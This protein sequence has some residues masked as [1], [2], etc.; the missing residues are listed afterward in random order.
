MPQRLAAAAALLVLLLPGCHGPRRECVPA[1][2]VRHG[3]LTD[4]SP[5][6]EA[7]QQSDP[8][9]FRAFAERLRNQ[10]SP[11]STPSRRINVLAL[12]GGG[13]YGAF[14]AGT[15][16]GWSETGRR[17]CFDIVT[18][19]STGALIA[20][21]AFLGPAYDDPLGRF[22]LS[23]R[24]QDVYH[25]RPYSVALF[26]DAAASSAPLE[27]LIERS[28]TEPMVQEIA[29]AHRQGRRLFVATTN[30]DTHRSVVWDLGAIAASGRPDALCLFR[31][32][33]LASASVPGFLPPV[34][35]DVEVNGRR[36]TEAH[37][38]GG[39]TNQVFL[40]GNA[41]G[42]DPDALRRGESPLK[43]S[44][45]YVIIAGKLYADP[46]CIRERALDIGRDAVSTL[47][48][49]QT[50]NDLLRVAFLCYLT[51][52]RFQLTSV[53]ADFP[54]SPDS[55]TFDPAEMRRLYDLGVALGRSGTAWR[56]SAPGVERDEQVL[57]RGGREFLAPVAEP[58]PPVIPP[59]P[60]P[61]SGRKCLR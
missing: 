48:Y 3:P 23:V 44:T 32:V 54:I 14:A 8:E 10:S 49:A 13:M 25:R 15:L 59:T 56:S 51:G 2:L 21:F 61:P 20:P 18:G 47:S 31:R 5:G 45:C 40:P 50:R 30:L 26:S 4:I 34:N 19:V 17:P 11:G 43:G 12:S 39:T 60:S 36:Y 58:A 35:I 6:A 41:L 9:I 28:V 52:M 55:M 27:R 29:A 46:G 42:I 7:Y 33:L 38:D 37:A 16:K 24:K 22:Y 57:P 1:A 53:P